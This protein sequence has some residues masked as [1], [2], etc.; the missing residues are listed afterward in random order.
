MSVYQ[1]LVRM[2]KEEKLS[3]HN[4]IVFN[5]YEFYPLPSASAVNLVQFKAAFLDQ[6]DIL[7]KHIYSPDGLRHKGKS[8]ECGRY[9]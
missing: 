9:D 3:L 5:V 6:I 4:V 8:L 2:H 7:P 1:E